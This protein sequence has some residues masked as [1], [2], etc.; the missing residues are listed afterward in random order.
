MRN[1]IAVALTLVL[2]S[3]LGVALWMRARRHA[4]AN[5]ETVLIV[6][7][8]GE[9]NA[10]PQERVRVD[11]RRLD[12]STGI[13][14]T[15]IVKRTSETLGESLVTGAAGEARFRV[16]P[17]TDFVVSGYSEA[18]R[19]GAFKRDV[20]GLFPG[21][22]RRVTVELALAEDLQFHGKVVT[23]NDQQPVS[24]ACVLVFS[25]VAET[26]SDLAS[27][28]WKLA[29]SR[30]AADG[31]FRLSLC[32]WEQP[33]VRVEAEGFGPS[34]AYVNTAHQTDETASIVPIERGATLNA[35]VVD[36]VGNSVPGI[37]VQLLVSADD[38]RHGDVDPPTEGVFNVAKLNW[39]GMTDSLGQCTVGTLP[40]NVSIRV[41]L[42]TDTQPGDASLQRDR[43]TG[44][45]AG[46]MIEEPVIL[47]P[48]EVRHV[49]WELGG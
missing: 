35:H 4:S 27:E 46:C 11:L 7:A 31:S 43:A 9:R 40:A 10:F 19:S 17:N 21:E 2:V 14:D 26:Y 36:S 23:L 18:G 16:P 12:A 8:V 3:V 6:E 41:R 24:G 39:C 32:S 30:T 33:Y 42:F 20:A 28:N 1:K 34:I 44:P 25:G 15:K 48:E 5:K 38:L 45:E 22:H 29:E 13:E 47:L 49:K 37:T